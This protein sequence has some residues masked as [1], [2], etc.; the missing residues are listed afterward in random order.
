MERE[1]VESRKLGAGSWTRQQSEELVS[2]GRVKGFV[3]EWLHDG[4]THPQLADCPWNIKF[5]ASPKVR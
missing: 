5:I 2:R 1:R 4:D 3:G